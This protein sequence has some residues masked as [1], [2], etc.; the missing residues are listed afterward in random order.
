MEFT[1]NDA[2]KI[3]SKFWWLILVV[4]VVCAAAGFFYGRSNKTT[5][6]TATAQLIVDVEYLEEIYQASDGT[7]SYSQGYN[8]AHSLVPTFEKTLFNEKT[9]LDRVAN[10]YY[11]DTGI[12]YTPSQVRKMFGFSFTTNT[13]VIDLSCTA[14]TGDECEALLTLLCEHGLERLNLVSSAVKLKIAEVPVYTYSFDVSYTSANQ[15]VGLKNLI[16][17][18][19]DEI[20]DHTRLEL[21]DIYLQRD[22]I[23]NGFKYKDKGN[24]KLEITY[25]NTN[26]SV[27]EFIVKEELVDYVKDAGMSLINESG[28]VVTSPDVADK[29][30]V[31]YFKEISDA[32]EYVSSRTMFYTVALGFV[33]FALVTLVAVIIYIS[34]E[35]KAVTDEAK[36]E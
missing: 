36:S 22:E 11:E 3:I 20:Y 26:E 30:D 24:G 19:N 32:K 33:G 16:E 17:D 29:P 35:K 21:S 12:L 4:T 10:A 27:V 6:Y 7:P 8:T 2:K 25:S 34:K 15:I 14:R 31:E 9:V 5:S 18:K 13:L 28:A 1:G 23:R